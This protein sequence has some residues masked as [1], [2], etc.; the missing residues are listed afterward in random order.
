MAETIIISIY[1]IIIIK[2]K[3]IYYK[4]KQENGKTKQVNWRKLTQNF[5]EC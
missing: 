1:I 2:V 4:G 5:F 3:N